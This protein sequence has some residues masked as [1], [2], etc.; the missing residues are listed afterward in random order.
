MPKYVLLAKATDVASTNILVR[1]ADGL[2]AQ[3]EAITALGGRVEAQFVVTG[4]YDIVLIVD[5]PTDISVLALS[6]A[7]NIGGLY[8]NALRAYSADE[9]D[10]A[11]TELPE[12]ESL[13]GAMA[14][15]ASQEE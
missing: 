15:E 10:S 7:S 13:L 11:R 2:N 9:L 14:A 8:V 12:I 5:M 4:N 1:G 6:L 3:H